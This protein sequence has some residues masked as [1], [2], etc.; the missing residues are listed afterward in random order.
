MKL[1]AEDAAKR[2]EFGNEIYETS[3]FQTKVAEAYANLIAN[4]TNVV[5]I[6]ANQPENDIELSISEAVQSRI[7]AIGNSDIDFY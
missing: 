3:E 6:D 4:H 7:S 5:E 1:S 2:G